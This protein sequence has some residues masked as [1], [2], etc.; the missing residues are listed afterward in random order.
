MTAHPD[1]PHVLGEVRALLARPG[2]DFAWS[3]WEDADAALAEI[4]AAIARIG[5][6]RRIPRGFAT[7]FAPTGPIQEVALSSGWSDEFL[8]LADRFETARK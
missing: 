8:A 2:N 1:L 3:S 4:D 5:V 6:G 7:L